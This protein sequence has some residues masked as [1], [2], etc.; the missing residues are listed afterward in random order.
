MKIKDFLTKDSVVEELHSVDK[1]GILKELAIHTAKH[2]KTLSYEKLVDILWEREKLGTT[3]L[4]KG[5][6]IPHVTVANID[7]MIATFG[8]SKHGVDFN[9]MDNNPTYIFFLLIS[10]QEATGQHLKA[11]ARISRLLMK[12]STR[13]KIMSAKN[14]DEIYETILE[15]DQP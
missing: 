12:A 15:E 13:Q 9:A 3:G 7:K 5:I 1:M 11:L 8:R 10:P 6:A 4:G 14:R 2:L